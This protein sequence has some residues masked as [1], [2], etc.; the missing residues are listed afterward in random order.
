MKRETPQT[1]IMRLLR[2]QIQSR[3]DEV[4]GGLSRAER[5]DYNRKDARINHLEILLQAQATAQKSVGPDASDRRRKSIKWAA[6]PEEDIPQENAR[7][8]Y[9]SRESRS[10]GKTTKSSDDNRRKARN[11]SDEAD[12]E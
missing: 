6:K 1:E 2:E 7:Q 12:G 4:F 11:D 3:E 5:A 9:R 10:S 8:P